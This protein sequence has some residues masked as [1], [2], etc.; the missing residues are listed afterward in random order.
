PRPIGLA[1][2][3]LDR[4]TVHPLTIAYYGGAERAPPT[5][6]PSRLRDHCVVASCRHGEDT[7]FADQ[8]EADHGQLAG[9]LAEGRPV[10]ADAG[11]GADEGPRPV[12][13]VL[14][15]V[16]RTAAQSHGAAGRSAG[17]Q[18]G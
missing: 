13:A 18:A 10:G 1:E 12:A 3:A 11:R 17:H 8:S 5:A 4:L 14:G 16:S 15:E 9:G 6:A 2:R 7:G